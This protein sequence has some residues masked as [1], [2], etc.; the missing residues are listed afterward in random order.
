LEIEDRVKDFLFRLISIPTTRGKEGEGVRYIYNEVKDFVDECNLIRIDD[1]FI[2]DPDYAFRLDNFTYKDTP[3]LEC[4]IKGTG[5]GKTVVFNAHVDVVPPS[6]G[7]ENPYTP[8]MKDGI[9]YGR[10]AVDDKGQIAVLYALMLLL[11]EK[12]IKFKG[13]IIFHFV[14]EEENGGNGTLAM[15]RRGVKADAVL[16]MESS[17]MDVITAARGAVWFEVEVTGKA[18]HS[19]QAG[20]NVNSITKAFDA[21][22]LM[23]EYHDKIL[24]ESRGNPLF[25]KFEDPMPV[26]FGQING[27][28]W[29]SITPSK[30]VF[31]GVFGFLPNKNRFE[32]QDGIRKYIKENGDDWLK[33][34]FKISFPML[35]SDGNVIPSDHPLVLSLQ[36]A[37]RKH[38]YPG[39]VKALPAST[40]AWFYNNMA[41]IPTVI[42]GAGYMKYAHTNNEQIPLK[43]VLNAGNILV[44]F[45]KDFSG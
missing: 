1:S 44:D 24:K 39:N 14:I 45:L 2:D 43:E 12:K 13:D 21:M 30:T 7:Q 16:D 3:E 18:G 10:G 4:I 6:A 8:V 20:K 36:K 37:I 29:P 28:D 27:G 40:D 33:D 31:K 23:K 15:V 38:S 32:I 35:N 25:D 17:E 34:H 26:N 42:F 19:G 9:V 41:K 22:K 5:N 11:K